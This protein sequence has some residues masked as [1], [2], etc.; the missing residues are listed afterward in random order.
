M[1]ITSGDSV[2]LASAWVVLHEVTLTGGGPVDSVRTNASGRYAMTL[3]PI[4]TTA[5]YLASIEH[6]GIGYFSEPIDVVSA[7]RDMVETLVVYDTSYAEPDIAV[8]ER[9]IIIRSAEDDGSRE[10]IELVVLLNAGR[11]TRI[12]G[13][14]SQ[15]VWEGA[16]PAGVIQFEVSESDVSPQAIF[17]RGN[18]IAVVA[19]IPPGEKQFLVSY[20]IPSNL[21]ELNIPL[22]H[23]IGRL[24]LLLED[25]TAVVAQGPVVLRGVEELDD[26]FFHR[27]SAVN[28][29]AGTVMVVRLDSAPLSAES[30]WWVL[31]ALAGVTLGGALIWWLKQQRQPVPQPVVH[32]ADTLAAQ[33]AALDMSVEDREVSATDRAS[34]QRH[35]AELKAQLSKML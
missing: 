9:H 32:D 19:P 3:S 20:L 27:Y 15:P 5:T 12:A 7:G 10:V 4:D 17:R 16:M 24:N 28:V 26:V 21:D 29:R 11:F 8:A 23:A 31:I 18:S 6:D 2:P 22:D 1:R 25:T 35:R 14:T 34:Y 13:D 33:I 30:L